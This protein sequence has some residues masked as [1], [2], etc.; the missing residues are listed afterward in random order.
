MDYTN[1]IKLYLKT[2]ILFKKPF[3]SLYSI[4]KNYLYIISFFGKIFIKL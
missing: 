3:D 4:L 1:K 2:I